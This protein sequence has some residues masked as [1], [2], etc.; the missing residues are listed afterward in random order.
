MAHA[1]MKARTPLATMRASVIKMQK[2]GERVVGRVRR[3]ARALIQR[4]RSE[5][6]KE[7]RGLERR[8]LKGIHAATEEQVAR[9]ERRIAKLEQLVTGL[10]ERAGGVF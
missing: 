3:D 9:L 6:L 7:V 5:V 10:Q 1:G 2:D 8:V 4:S